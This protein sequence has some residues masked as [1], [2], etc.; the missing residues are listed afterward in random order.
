MKYINMDDTFRNK[1]IECFESKSSCSTISDDLIIDLPCNQMENVSLIA[2]DYKAKFLN[3]D[4]LNQMVCTRTNGV[5]WIKFID[6]RTGSKM[7]KMTLLTS[8]NYGSTIL[9][10]DK[11]K[12]A[13]NEL[14]TGKARIIM[15]K[16]NLEEYYMD[17]E[18]LEIG[19]NNKLNF[20][21]PLTTTFPHNLHMNKK[22]ENGQIKNESNCVS[23]ILST[24]TNFKLF[25]QN[26]HLKLDDVIENGI[27]VQVMVQ[28]FIG[29][30]D[31]LF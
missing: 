9:S 2:R 3:Y 15:V 17:F 10:F 13:L 6:L 14:R 1:L 26:I 7:N 25:E 22:F 24:C 12:C 8:P 4:Y 31:Y 30:D 29:I 23:T 28:A 19:S 18:R 27:I 21:N 11:M 20:I 5:Y 16:P